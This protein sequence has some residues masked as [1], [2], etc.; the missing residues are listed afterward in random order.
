M[1]EQTTYIVIERLHDLSII[2]HV[3]LELILSKCLATEI[4]LVEVDTDAVVKVIV[5]RT[6]LRVKTSQEA[7]IGGKE[8]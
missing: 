5:L 2:A 8:V 4:A 3:A 6:I 7:Q 1:I